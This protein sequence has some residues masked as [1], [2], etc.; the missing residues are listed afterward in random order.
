LPRD[1]TAEPAR[2]G[3]PVR[4]QM[5]AHGGDAPDPRPAARA[6]AHPPPAAPAADGLRS[7]RSSHIMTF[8]DPGVIGE[9]AARTQGGSIVLLSGRPRTRQ[10][11][12]ER[13][14]ATQ[15]LIV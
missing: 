15:S 11:A 3:A 7:L 14:R 8:V 4:R 13:G 1:R 2:A 12:A 9:C 10:R 5:A 6:R